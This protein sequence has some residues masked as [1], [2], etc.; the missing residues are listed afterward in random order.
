MSAPF[1]LDVFRDELEIVVMDVVAGGPLNDKLLKSVRRV[2]EARL[3]PKIGGWL[4]GEISPREQDETRATY[5]HQIEKSEGELGWNM[6]AVDIWRRVRAYNPWPG[7]YTSWRGEKLSIIDADVLPVGDVAGAGQVIT[8]PGDK[9][10]I[11]I[12]T[13]DGVLVVRRVK[14]AGK[15][16]MSATEFIRGQRDFIGS[17]LPS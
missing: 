11:G 16:A 13:G 17:V 8:L 4:R 3:R 5:F 7:T 1:D 10:S 14:L 15:K 2:V 6:P 12:G 9:S